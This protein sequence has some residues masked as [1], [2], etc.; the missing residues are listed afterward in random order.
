[1]TF[2]HERKMQ[3]ASSSMSL[4]LQLGFFSWQEEK[5]IQETNLSETLLQK[6]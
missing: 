1:M 4:C 6:E 3:N 5:I 2:S